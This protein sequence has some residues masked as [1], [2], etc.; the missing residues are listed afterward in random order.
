MARRICRVPCVDTGLFAFAL[1]DPSRFPTDDGQ[2][3][4]SALLRPGNLFSVCA[5]QGTS[6]FD[7][8]EPI[9][10]PVGRLF[11]GSCKPDFDAWFDRKFIFSRVICH[12]QWPHRVCVGL[13]HHTSFSDDASCRC[14]R[15]CCC[16]KIN[17]LAIG[18]KCGPVLY[19]TWQAANGER[20]LGHGGA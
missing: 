5:F 3:L 4:V 18:M 16:E 1:H 9:A 6:V 15:F 2:I 10:W 19:R 7:M 14:H 11:G 13:F 12:T 8:A 17:S 20:T